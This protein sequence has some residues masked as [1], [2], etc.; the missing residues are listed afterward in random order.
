MCLLG[1]QKLLSSDTPHVP[2]VLKL[3]CALESAG[4]L[5]KLLLSGVRLQGFRY[6]CSRVQPGGGGGGREGTVKISP[7]DSHM[8][9]RWRSPPQPTV[10][11]SPHCKSLFLHPGLREEGQEGWGMAWMADL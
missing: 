8:Q 1:K 3:C 10:L 7:G 6:N 11:L 2:L 9:P 4:E 5:Y